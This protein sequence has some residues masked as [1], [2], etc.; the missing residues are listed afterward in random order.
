MLSKRIVRMDN[1]FP[2]AMLRLFLAGLLVGGVCAGQEMGNVVIGV[3][4]GSFAWI[5][6]S[7][8]FLGGFLILADIQ[9][10]VE[11]ISASSE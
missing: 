11:K 7:V 2:E 1:R 3:F 4:A 5:V 10:S 9:K 8:V 6:V